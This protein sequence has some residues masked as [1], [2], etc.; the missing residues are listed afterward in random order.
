MKDITTTTEQTNLTRDC[1]PLKYDLQWYQPVVENVVQTFTQWL[2]DEN[3]NYRRNF[4]DSF[5]KFSRGQIV[6]VIGFDEP[7]VRG[8]V[9][10]ISAGNTIPFRCIDG[11]A[12]AE[13]GRSDSYDV[14][15]E[16]GH[17]TTVG[18]RNLR[19]KRMYVDEWECD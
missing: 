9:D 6:W 11:A 14:R 18:P 8:V 19:T 2:D 13:L 15:F 1:S 10:C 12:R 17:V 16:T 3:K 7:P 4:S 5:G